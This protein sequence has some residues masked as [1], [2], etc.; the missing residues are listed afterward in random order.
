MLLIGKLYQAEKERLFHLQGGK[1]PLCGRP[2]EDDIQ[3]NHLDHDHALEG[4]NAGRVR[5]LLC[6]LCNGTEGIMKHKFNRS[7]LAGRGVDYVEW[8]EELVQYLKKDCS[9]NALHPQYV[10]DMAKSFSRLG[11]DEMIAEMVSRGFAYQA[12]WTKANLIKAFKKE[13]RKSCKD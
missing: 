8:L 12:D 10:T 6:N 1:C 11:K 13:F 3:A 4:K 2:L 9:D 7:G 5:A